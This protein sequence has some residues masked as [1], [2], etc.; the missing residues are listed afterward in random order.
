MK[1]QFYLYKRDIVHPKKNLK[2]Q[3]PIEKL[4]NV[5]LKKQSTLYQGRLVIN[6]EKDDMLHDTSMSMNSFTL[7]QREQIVT[8]LTYLP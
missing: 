1:D 2:V 6:Y 5:R 8:H 3:I 7:T 4:K